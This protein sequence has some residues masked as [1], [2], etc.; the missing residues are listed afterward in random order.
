MPCSSCGIS[1]VPNM[2]AAEAIVAAEEGFIKTVARLAHH[3][4]DD[5]DV[6]KLLRDAGNGNFDIILDLTA[7]T[8]SISTTLHMPV[9]RVMWFTWCP[10]LVQ[11]VP[12]AGWGPL[13]VRC[14]VKIGAH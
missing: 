10:G 3:L 1:I 4:H 5:A 13:A 2:H 11:D 7:F 9:C 8:P 6:R 12:G 14:R